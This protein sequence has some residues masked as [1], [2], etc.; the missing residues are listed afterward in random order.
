MHG[1]APNLLLHTLS[2]S[3]SRTASKDGLAGQWLTTVPSTVNATSLSR[4]ELMTNVNLQRDTKPPRIP[5]HCDGCGAK[6]SVE[7]SLITNE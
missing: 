6:S 2:V 4:D 5:S 1:S 7:R 3:E